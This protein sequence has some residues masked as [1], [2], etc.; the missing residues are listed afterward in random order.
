MFC[1]KESLT[2]DVTFLKI[3]LEERED[4]GPIFQ[5]NLP[6]VHHKQN[7]YLAYETKGVSRSFQYLSIY[8]TQRKSK[9]VSLFLVLST[10]TQR[11]ALVIS[12]AQTT[13]LFVLLRISILTISRVYMQFKSHVCMYVYIIYW[14]DCRRTFKNDCSKDVILLCTG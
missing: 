14:Q 7:H 8:I 12:A 4:W 13:V 9:Q 3:S 2:H 11:V 10:H 5:V 6:K 1:T